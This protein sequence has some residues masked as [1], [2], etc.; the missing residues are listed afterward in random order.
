MEKKT[1]LSG[2]RMKGFFFLV[3]GLLLL[4][5]MAL[6]VMANGP[7]TAALVFV[8]EQAVNV[9]GDEQME[10]FSA[11]FR[12]LRDGTV[13]G[14]ATIHDEDGTNVYRFTSGRVVCDIAYR[15]YLLLE[16]EASSI[17]NEKLLGGSRK[18]KATVILNGHSNTLNWANHWQTAANGYVL[19]GQTL[20]LE[21]SCSNQALDWFTTM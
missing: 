9:D 19:R 16:G 5:V 2:T 17:E 3:A 4:A 13:V 7:D 14:R 1:V 6:T 18:F 10:R 15:S 11:S 8:P 21:E 12:V 20:L